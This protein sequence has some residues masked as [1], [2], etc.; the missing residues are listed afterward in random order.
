VEADTVTMSAKE[1]DRLH[2][3]RLLA[4]HRATQRQAAEAWA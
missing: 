3:M 1:V 4:E 2:W